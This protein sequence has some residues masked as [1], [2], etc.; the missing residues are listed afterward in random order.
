MNER[1]EQRR[2]GE[3][4]VKAAGERVNVKDGFY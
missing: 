1:V 4:N 3:R 2:A